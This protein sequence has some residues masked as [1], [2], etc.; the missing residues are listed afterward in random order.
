MAMK[1]ALSI[2]SLLPAALATTCVAESGCAGCGQVASASFVQDGSD[3]VADA[4]GWGT[5]TLSG[6][7]IELENVSGSVLTI[8]NYG[9][10]CYYI[11][12]HSSCTVGKPDSFNTGLG[13]Q[14]WQH[15]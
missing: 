7:T 1:I 10:V 4:P 11:S 8:C 12:E 2:L 15:P 13:I 9:T 14:V 5:L 6:S 3:L